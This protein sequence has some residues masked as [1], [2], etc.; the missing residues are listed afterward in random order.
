MC[1]SAREFGAQ[2][3]VSKRQNALIDELER[4]L[5]HRFVLWLFYTLQHRWSGGQDQN[6]RKA[7]AVQRHRR[8]VDDCRARHGASERQKKIDRCAGCEIH[9]G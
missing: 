2:C 8:L 4:F 5:A 1:T 6:R 7:G 9:L 3:R